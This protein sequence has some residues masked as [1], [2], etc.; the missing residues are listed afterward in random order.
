MPYSSNSELPSGVRNAL[1]EEAQTAWRHV[2]NNAYH[3]YKDDGQ[4]AATAWTALERAGWKKDDKGNWVKIA[5]EFSIYV[6]ISKMDDEQQIVFG[7]GSVTKVDGQP[8]EDMQGD[9][10]EDYELEKA[11]YDFMLAPKHDEM[12]ERIVPDSVIVESFVATDEKLQKMF[13]NM[14]ITKGNRGWWLGIKVN[15]KDVYQKHKLGIYKGFSITGTA[16]RK[17]VQKE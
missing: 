9:I 12:H 7:W 4:A 6:P 3:Q 5:K 1:P 17:E 8:V 11:V 10:I 15:D 2:F 16:I 14:N 13:P